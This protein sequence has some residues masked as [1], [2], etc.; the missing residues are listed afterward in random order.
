MILLKYNEANNVVVTLTEKQTFTPL[1]YL[2]IFKS[3]NLGKQYGCAA[4]NISTFTG[5]YNEFII[6]QSS[7]PDLLNGV[8]TLGEGGYYSYTIYGI[9]EVLDLTELTAAIQ[10][11]Q[12]ELETAYTVELLETGKMRYIKTPTAMTEFKAATENKTVFQN[13]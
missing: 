12:S 13:T 8:I 1:Q 2:F 3:G 10:M 6:T 9:D 4:D 7:T 11:S 5:R